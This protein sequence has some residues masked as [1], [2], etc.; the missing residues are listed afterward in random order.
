MPLYLPQS[1]TQAAGRPSSCITRLG[2]SS[3]NFSFMILHYTTSS[4][5]IINIDLQSIIELCHN[6]N[7]ICDPY[8]TKV[9]CKESA[10]PFRRFA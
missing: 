2:R 10:N 9:P 5:K 4:P 3:Q 6:Y 7:N 8:S 1:P